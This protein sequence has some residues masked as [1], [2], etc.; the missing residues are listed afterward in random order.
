MAKYYGEIGFETSQDDGNGIWNEKIIANNYAGDIL[1]DNR[2]LQTTSNLNDDI[3]VSN[4]ISIIAD[5]FAYQN[6][7]SIRYAEYMGIKWKVISVEVQ[8]P[9][10]LLTLGGVYIING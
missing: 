9:R 3:V 2:R 6:F 4:Q 5:P 7:H 10:L 1:K 8:Y